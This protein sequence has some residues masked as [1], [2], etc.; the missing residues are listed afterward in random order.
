MM[1]PCGLHSSPSYGDVLGQEVPLDPSVLVSDVLLQPRAEV[2]IFGVALLQ[3][4]D[5]VFLQ[6]F[7]IYQ[8]EHHLSLG[9]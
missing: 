1:V 2:Q 9:S 6:S 8:R 5:R 4:V 3:D 7:G